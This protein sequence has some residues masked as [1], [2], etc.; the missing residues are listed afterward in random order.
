MTASPPPSHLPSSSVTSSPPPSVVLTIKPP[1]PSS[2]NPSPSS[3]S[4]DHSPSLPPSSSLERYWPFIAVTI[5]SIYLIT[6]LPFIAP[7][8]FLLQFSLLRYIRHQNDKTSEAKGAEEVRKRRRATQH[9]MARRRGSMKPPVMEVIAEEE[10]GEGG[11]EEV[12]RAAAPAAPAQLHRPPP[13]I[14][15]QYNLG[16]ITAPLPVA[17]SSSAP[18]PP[19]PPSPSPSSFP[20]ASPSRSWPSDALDL[21]ES[22]HSLLHSSMLTLERGTSEGQGGILAATAAL[23]APS[24]FQSLMSPPSASAAL[25]PSASP[26]L[27]SPRCPVSLPGVRGAPA[28]KSP[29]NFTRELPLS[30]SLS[31]EMHH[32]VARVED[33]D[34]VGG[35]VG[36]PYG[37]QGVACAV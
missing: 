36:G 13:L 29:F 5:C 12:G 30:P 21:N 15:P 17:S 35:L 22:F 4:H 25:P 27:S 11:E 2:F 14:I 1:T 20:P 31:A 7:G 3:P 9:R 28:R 10:V 18:F 32:G 16:V 6:L 19:D 8:M 23:F 24:I 34:E 26:P 33:E 37:L